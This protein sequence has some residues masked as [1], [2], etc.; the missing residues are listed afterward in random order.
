MAFTILEEKGRE[1]SRLNYI[2]GDPEVWGSV[3]DIN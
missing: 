1:D 3:G 2:R